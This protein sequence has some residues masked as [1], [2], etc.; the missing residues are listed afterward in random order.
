MNKLMWD[1][2]F[3]EQISDYSVMLH[4]LVKETPQDEEEYYGTYDGCTYVCL[5]VLPFNKLNV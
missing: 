2:F 1:Q 5:A 3:L 4:T